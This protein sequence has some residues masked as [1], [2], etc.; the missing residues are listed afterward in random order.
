M[1]PKVMKQSLIADLTDS[2][3][4]PAAAANAVLASQRAALGIHCGLPTSNWPG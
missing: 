3:L 1:V 4:R 2:C